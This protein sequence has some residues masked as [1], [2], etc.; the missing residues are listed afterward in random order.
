M[1]QLPV[2]GEKQ[3]TRSCIFFPYRRES[4]AVAG[5]PRHGVRVSGTAIQLLLKVPVDHARGDGKR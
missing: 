1:N 4:N 2:K 5:S 3:N